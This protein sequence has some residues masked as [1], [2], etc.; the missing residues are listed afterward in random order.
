MNEF[1][2]CKFVE[3]I[4]TNAI[5]FGFSSEMDDFGKG[6]IEYIGLC[7]N[8]IYI[9]FIFDSDKCDF[10]VNIG[11]VRYYYPCSLSNVHGYIYSCL[12]DPVKF[13]QDNELN[14]IFIDD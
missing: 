3:K 1:E 2:K 7:K 6:K 11:D 13:V 12:C 9:G 4:T 14:C 5:K 10:F 8:D